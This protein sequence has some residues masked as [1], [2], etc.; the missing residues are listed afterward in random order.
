MNQILALGGG[1]DSTVLALIDADRERASSW[2]GIERAVLDAVFPSCS[3]WVFAD[4]GAEFA[5]TYANIGRLEEVAALSSKE[6]VTV[7]KQGENIQEWLLRLGTVPLMPGGAHVCSLKFKGEV[8][9]AWAKDKFEGQP[10]NWA[11]GIEANEERRHK[12]FTPAKDSAHS[13]IYPLREL[14]LARADCERLLHEWGWGEVR[15]SSCVFCPFM[16]SSEII[17]VLG[18]PETAP[19]VHAIERRFEQTS[20]LKYARWIEEGCPTNKAGRAPHGMW[21]RD[22]WKE[23]SRLFAK[24]VGGKRLSTREWE[25]FAKGGELA[26]LEYEG[27]LRLFEI[28]P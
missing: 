7:R 23:G 17:A 15:K 9:Q 11:V 10:V 5:V 2:L 19:L 14:E 13:F 25:Q 21:R 16:Q 8:M 28:G 12:R 6:L 18:D 3:H 26:L 4:P 22:S 1:V 24:Q 20:P 27:Q